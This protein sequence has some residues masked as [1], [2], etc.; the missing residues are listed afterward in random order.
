M[1]MAERDRLDGMVDSLNRAIDAERAGI[2]MSPQEMFEVFGDF[3]PAEHETEAA[4]RWPDAYATSKQRTS[5]Y[6]KQTWQQAVA[7]GEAIAA[8]FAALL[9][10]GAAADDPEA[11]AVAEEHRLSID[12]WY[13]P[14]SS[15]IHAGL[16]DMYVADPRFEQ[17]WEE[18]AAGLAQF[19]HDA[20]KANAAR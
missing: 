17:H 10:S 11:Q 5:Q 2:K 6:D 20:I 8:R 1:I 4:D 14:C 7:D 15:E 12:R 9:D 16:A 19:V 13:Y 18:R 3:N